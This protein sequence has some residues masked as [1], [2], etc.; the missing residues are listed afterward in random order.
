M[1]QYTDRA[2]DTAHARGATY[3]DVRIVRRTTEDI[4][5]KNGVIEALA[6]D[7]SYGFGVRVLADGAWG[8]ASSRDVSHGEIDR[9]AAQAVAIAKASASVSRQPV[10][11]APEA[12]VRDRY[13]T[14]I[15]RD[16][17]TVPLDE[18]IE[19]L[20]RADAAARAV[21]GL[22]I[23]QGSLHAWREDKTFASSEGSFIEQTLTQTGLGM[24]ATAVND[25]DVQERSYPDSF[26]QWMSKGW[27]ITNEYDLPAHAE[28]VATEAVQLLSAPQC[29]SGPTTIILDGPQM[30]IQIHESCGHPIELDRVLGMEAAYAGTS[31]LTTDKLRSSYRYGSECV[32]MTAD[33]TLPG[34]LGSFGYDDEG[35][36]AQRTDIVKDGIFHGYLTDRQ[37]AALIGLERS[38]G[39]SRAENWNRLAMIRMTNVS[40]LPGTWLLD[41]L[42]ADTGDGLYILTNRSWSIDDKRLNFQFGCELAYEIKN[43]KLGRMFKNP[44]YQGM[45][46]QFWGG[47]DAVCNNDHWTIWGTPNCGKGQPGQVG[48]TGHGAAPARFRNIQV[49]VIG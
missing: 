42:I 39:C 8:F 47:C 21:K 17:F 9:V 20:L 26:G 19:Y 30:A 3:A 41:D 25:D 23:F 1:N 49:G 33:A 48:H 16:P 2:L 7:E 40:L 35:V 15:E 4:E 36:P 44:T 27:E 6:Q 28:R 12:P 38:G 24:H 46:P 18:K 11:L 31:F 29:P 43:G 22:A 45:T 32:N 14:P 13:A 5:L 10:V 37:T 34:G